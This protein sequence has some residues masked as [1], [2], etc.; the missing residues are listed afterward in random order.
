M[1]ITYGFPFLFEDVDE[2]IDPVIDNVLERNIK[3]A[4]S[5]KFIVLGDKEV[6]FD[7]NFRL[8]MTSKL[9]N[10][11][12][13]A[14]VFGSC[15]V[16]NYSVTLKGLQDQLLNVVVG[17]ERRELEEQR[18]RLVQEM[19]SNKT[20]LKELE[21]TLLRELASSTGMILDNTELIKTLE[22][23]KT[24][25]TEIAQKLVLANQTAKD[26]EQSRDGYR[27]VAKCGA[28]LYFVLAEL[29]VINPMYEYSLAAFLEVFN[30]SLDRSKTDP[31]LSKRLA[32]ISDTLKYSVYCYACT[33][34]FERH[35]LMF[36]LQMTIKLMEGDETMDPTELDFFLKGNTSLELP[37]YPK[38][39]WISLQGWKD[40]CKLGEFTAFKSLIQEIQSNPGA[41]RKWI[42]HDAPETI[43]APL[44][45]VSSLMPFQN[46]CLLRCVRPD[47]VYNAATSFVISQM[48]E[49]YVMPPVINY[50]SVFEQSSPTTA[51]VFILSPGA[52]PASDVA[53][54]AESTGFGGNRLKFLSLGQG[55][56]PIALQLLEM[57]VARGQWLMLQNCHLLVAWLRQLEKVLDKIEKPHKDF[58]LWLTTE[59]TSSFPIGILQRSLKVVTEPPNGLKLNLRATYFRVTED[60]LAESPHPAFRPLAYVLAFFHAVVQE[61]SKYGK[62]GWNVKYDFNESDFR[63]SFS[64]LKIYLNKSMDKIPWSTL[65]YL[66][67]ETTYGGRVT[68][69]YDRRVVNT[70]LEEYMGDFV[71]DTHQRFFFF[72]ND[73]VQ[74]AVP[75]QGTRDEYLSVVEALPLT[76]APDVFGLHPDA[77]I[78]YLTNFVRDMW[79]HL[80]ALQPR[81]MAG[82]GGMSRDDMI[83][84]TAKEILSRIPQA[85]DVLKIRKHFGTPTPTQIVLL[86]ELERWNLLVERMASSLKDLQR[87]LKGE[88]GMSQKLDEL[89]S[90]LFNGT[91]PTQWKTLAPQTEKSL[92]S[93]MAH[94]ERR[95]QQYT[96]WIKNG[97]PNV[98]WLSGLHVPESYLTAL[99]QVACRKNGWSLDRSTLYTQVTEFQDPKE[100]TERPALGCY[101][102]GLSLEGARWNLATG[103]LDRLIPGSGLVQPLPILRIIPIEL[104]KLKLINTFKTPVYTTSQRRNAAGV[105]WVFDADLATKNHPSHWVLQ[106]VCLVMNTTD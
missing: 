77:E 4:G 2:Y 102:E 45:N 84:N 59:P 93:W 33:G 83:S 72:K 79:A 103:S 1:A 14:K 50:Q 60:M 95:Y 26:V 43:A 55:Q 25:A 105:G 54:L 97:E 19:S 86:Q 40:L 66:I 13:S 32:K 78:G 99:V 51:V 89:A 69:E 27:P 21:D 106:G 41:W 29:S 100:V 87:A 104:A 82:A 88:I 49:K 7:P 8:Y 75:L 90:N 80:V 12:Y 52:D 6:D 64:T 5:R 81:R 39:D 37:G 85:V 47:R 30:T 98:M 3:T 36:S 46:L 17:H 20:L 71:F 73:A 91:L 76:N 18:E 62:I 15:T 23:T 56:G 44:T 96:S 65:R 70:Y 61:R 53:K 11:T 48:G 57:A 10:P 22:E 92:G 38:P 28:I 67:G 34:L 35:K 16:I 58:R 63:V 31:V 42:D 24:K 9:S 101:I 68:D 94:F 74:Y